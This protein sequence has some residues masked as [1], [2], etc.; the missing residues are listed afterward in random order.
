M[1]PVRTVKELG[2]LVRDR[3][4]RL[5]LSQSAL[6]ERVG[7]SRQW[8]VEVEAGKPRAAIGMI[9]RTLAVRGVTLGVEEPSTPE[10]T[11]KRRRASR[12]AEPD[13]DAIVQASRKP[14]P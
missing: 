11:P 3:R 13:I 4:G 8:I 6:A 12:M 14:R 5:G 1:I 2:A 7:V 10:S 9:L